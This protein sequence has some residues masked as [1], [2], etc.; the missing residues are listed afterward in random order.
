MLY[1]YRA[2]PLRVIDGDTVRFRIDLGCNVFI[3]ETMRL[4]GIDADEIRKPASPQ[5]IASGKEAAMFL[6]HLLDNYSDGDGYV[7]IRT[8]KDRKGKFGR[9]L[10][11]IYGFHP[12]LSSINLNT[13]MITQ[14][15]AVPRKE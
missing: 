8:E 12:N 5:E 13:E 10:V 7:E 4:K 14:D 1:T 11:T 15:Y 2:K 9:Y 3:E 6:Q